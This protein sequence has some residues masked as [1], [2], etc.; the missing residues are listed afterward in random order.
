MQYQLC[1]EKKNPKFKCFWGL[2]FN[3]EHYESFVT[4][5]IPASQWSYVRLELDSLISDNTS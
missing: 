5:E 3:I 1:M 2:F 4:V